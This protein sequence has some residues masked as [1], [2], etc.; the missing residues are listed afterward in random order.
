[1]EFDKFTIGFEELK[2]GNY[3]Y[4]FLVNTTFFKGLGYSEILKGEVIVSSIFTKSERLMVMSLSFEGKV[5]LPCDRCGENFE[6]A[7]GFQES[8]VIKRGTEEDEDDG[9]IILKEDATEFDI[10]HYLYES[11]ILSLPTKRVHPEVDGEPRCD[12]ALLEQIN[13]KDDSNN[14]NDDIDPRWSALKD[15]K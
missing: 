12:K 13:K 5:V 3:D 11:I 2:L 8:I 7:V 1:M 15:L 6:E 9:V 4:S 14:E 10:S